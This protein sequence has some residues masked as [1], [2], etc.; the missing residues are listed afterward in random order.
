M[1]GT[2]NIEHDAF[3]QARARPGPAFATPDAV[4]NYLHIAFEI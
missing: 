1:S 3:D 4:I 2:N